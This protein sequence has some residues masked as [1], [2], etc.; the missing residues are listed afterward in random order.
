MS[1]LDNTK[2][3]WSYVE[4]NI[5]NVMKHNYTEQVNIIMYHKHIKNN[6]KMENV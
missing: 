5:E 4:E 1:C 6:E 2:Y 3:F